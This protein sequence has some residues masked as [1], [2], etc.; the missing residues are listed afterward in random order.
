MNDKTKVRIGL[1]VMVMALVAAV[2]PSTI[3]YLT[4]YDSVA[5]MV[6]YHNPLGLF[7][8]AYVRGYYTT[9]DGGEGVF[10]PTNTVS[11]TNYGTRFKSG[12]TGASAWSMQRV[13][14]GPVHV[15]WFGALPD[16]SDS[17]PRIENAIRFA[18]NQTLIINA[19]VYGISAPL[20]IMS[21]TSIV[22]EG[23]GGGDSSLNN[24][25]TNPPLATIAR[26]G[27]T[28]LFLRGGANCP[29]FTND[30]TAEILR[31]DSSTY[32]GRGIITQRVY[33]A[34]IRN[35]V[36][37][38]NGR[39]QTRYDCD[40]VKLTDAW[41]VYFQNTDFRY[42]A[43]Y[44]LRS[45]NCNTI[46]LDSCTLVG[47]LA[48]SKGIMLYDS[49]DCQING[50][51]SGGG[52]VGPFLW[53]ATPTGWLNNIGGAHFGDT[54]IIDVGG[55]VNSVSANVMTLSADPR[56]ETGDPFVFYTTNGVTAGVLSTNVVQGNTYF[57]IRYTAT[58]F[59]FSANITNALLGVKDT[60]TDIGS[61]MF[62]KP[63]PSVGLY[64]SQATRNV[65]SNMR[66]D[67]GHDGCVVM[68]DAYNNIVTS[69][70]ISK[71]GYNGGGTRLDRNGIWIR[72]GTGNIVSDNV[73]TECMTPMRIDV[74]GNYIGINRP[75]NCTSNS[76]IVAGTREVFT[77]DG[78][79]GSVDILLARIA[80]NSASVVPLS[81][82]SSNNA[83]VAL[84]RRIGTVV[85]GANIRLSDASDGVGRDIIQFADTNGVVSV[86]VVLGS[87]TEGELVLGG[88]AVPKH[89]VIRPGYA[90]GSNQNGF[91]NYFDA[92]GGT[93]N[94][95]PGMA[96][97]R[98]PTPLGSGVS[99]QTVKSNVFSVS[100]TNIFMEAPFSII[101]STEPSAP[102]AT[103]AVV[104]ADSSGGK[105]RLRVRFP[106]GVSQTIAT[107]P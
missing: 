34:E 101:V 43:G 79:D 26:V 106:T 44:F 47:E 53:V 59:G 24:T 51:S 103:H 104:F 72:S 35:L 8:T 74:A 81:L 89:G 83:T 38:G 27:R 6:A 7:K 84:L 71:P 1:A 70:V 87:T 41:S 4:T 32:D 42:P 96:V 31:L 10:Y 22:G 92:G 102:D 80:S 11:G 78:N 20:S 28:V 66:W 105:V 52:V 64:L 14:S 86:G 77:K 2:A 68:E 39:S 57:A 61:L 65:F 75:I 67:N 63:G 60:I 3:H 15:R 21:G 16:G 95:S 76:V 40:L 33:N 49:A 12:I 18:T 88:D 30:M 56:L 46:R 48:K 23:V 107:E 55:I 17:Q 100:L 36:L 58:T 82:T 5:D 45:W 90:S 99:I 50:V 97:I 73:F 93:G 13:Y 54:Q 25:V 98:V 9:G 62:V 85:S 29:M 19:G 94:G 69:S 37:H 91:T